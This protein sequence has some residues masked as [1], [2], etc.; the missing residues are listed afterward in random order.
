MN[1]SLVA[2]KPH[3]VCIPI[4]FQSHIIAMLKLAKLLHLK[5]FHITFVNTEYNHQRILKSRGADSLNGLPDFKFETIPDGLPAS[6]VNASQD[7]L[8]LVNSM[9]TNFL[10]PFRN[11]ITKLNEASSAFSDNPPVTCIVSDVFMSFP[12]EAA[13][14]FG[15]PIA[16]LCTVSACVLMIYHHCQHLERE[17][18]PLKDKSDLTNEHLNRVVDLIPGVK[19]IRLKD[20][21]SFFLDGNHVMHNSLQTQIE[22]APR[23]SAIII[24]TFDAL[25]SSVLGAMRTLLPPMYTMGPLQLLIEQLAPNTQLRSIGSNLW[26]E[27]QHCIQWLDFQELNS[28]VYVNFGS[29]TVM[30]PEQLIEIAWGLANS[31]HPFLWVI[32]SDLVIGEAAILPPE[33]TQE[34]ADRGMISGWCPQEQVLIHSSTGGFLTHS[35][36]NSIMDTISGGVPVISWPFFGDQQTNCRETCVHWGIGMEIDNN[37]KRD[38]VEGL[39]RELMEGEKGKVMKKKAMGWKKSAEDSTEPGG[40]SYMNLDKVIDEVLIQKELV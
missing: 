21:P 31:K 3:A 2:N 16:L 8:A 13:E 9:D 14:E 11:V 23:A 20:L 15:I 5:G 19:G 28:V 10:G 7:T 30:T 22:R 32:R 18:L 25:E 37:V 40:S 17:L 38:N 24:N 36:W 1:S 39:V 33:F 29:H 26:I 12:V 35:G 6:D 27:D 4:P 34:I